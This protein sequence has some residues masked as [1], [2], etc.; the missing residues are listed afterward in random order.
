MR[1]PVSLQAVVNELEVVSDEMRAYINRETGELYTLTSEDM[2]S[3]EI[4][5]D[6]DD[7]PDWQKD[8][9]A[10]AKE[11]LEG[12]AWLPLPSKFDINEWE[13]MRDFARSQPDER[14]AERLLR[15]IHGSG[16]FR[17]F[18]DIVFDE[19]LRDAWF[20]FRDRAVEEIAELFLNAAKIPYKK[21]AE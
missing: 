13:I 11:I 1:L 10:K 7:V 9:T 12:D 20:A 17:Y 18:K 21:E 16:A 15:A 4:D 5:Y 19:G 3:A 8:S 6:E 14:L 2:D